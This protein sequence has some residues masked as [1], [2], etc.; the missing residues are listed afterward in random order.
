MLDQELK[1]I[2][3]DLDDTLWDFTKN[4]SL[5]F[6]FIFQKRE[7]TAPLNEFLKAYKPINEKYW[8]LYRNQEIQVNELRF[9]RL[10]DSFKEMGFSI[11]EEMIYLLVDDFI[12]HL[13]DFNHLFPKTIETLQYLFPK[14]SLHILTNGFSAVQQRK[15]EKSRLKPYFKTITASEENGIKKPDP[16]IFKLALQKAKAHKENSLMIGDNFE[17]DI[18]GAQ[19][20]GLKTIYFKPERTSDFQGIQIQ[21]IDQLMEIL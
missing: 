6:E 16:E 20:M 4:S 21:E 12:E 14:Y 11:S 19:A 10:S 9:L 15:I 1:H 3:F 5:A 2:F 18:L 8:R 13:I 7:L 17:A